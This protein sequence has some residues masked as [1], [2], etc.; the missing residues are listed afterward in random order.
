MSIARP[1]EPTKVTGQ[2]CLEYVERDLGFA[3]HGDVLNAAAIERYVESGRYNGT[4]VAGGYGSY[5]FQRD[6]GSFETELLK[7]SHDTTKRICG[8]VLDHYD[9]GGIKVAILG[10]ETLSTYPETC[11][12]L[13][14][15]M[16]LFYRQ[17]YK[18]GVIET[19]YKI[20]NLISTYP[21]VLAGSPPY[22]EESYSYAS[23]LLNEDGGSPSYATFDEFNY[24][25]P[26][27]IGGV[28]LSW[29]GQLWQYRG[30]TTSGHNYTLT[31]DKDNTL[32]GGVGFNS[33]TYQLPNLP[34]HAL[35]C[36]NPLAFISGNIYEMARGTL[37][38]LLSVFP[39]MFLNYSDIANYFQVSPSTEPFIFN[40]NL[41]FIPYNLILFEN[42]QDAKNYLANGVVTSDAYLYPLDF[43]NLPKYEAPDPDDDED[44]EDHNTPDDN[45]RET[46]ENLPETPTYTP[47]RLSNYNWYWIDAQELEGFID[48]FWNDVGDM[49]DW[50]DL[51][52]KIKGLYNDLASAILMIRYMPVDVNWIGGT[53]GTGSIKVGMIEK[54][55][56]YSMISDIS[57]P[58]VQLIGHIEIPKNYESFVDL[59][60]YAELSLYLPY[61]GIVSLDVDILTG[62]SLYVYG[63]YDH[64]NG[65]IQYYLYYDNRTLINTYIAKMAVDIPITLQSKYDR[66]SAIF[67]NVSNT[68]GG[69][70]SA[71]AGVASGNPIG[72]ALGVTQGVSALTTNSNA[73]A[74]LK[75]MGTVGETG[76]FYAPQKCMLYHRRAVIT[77]PSSWKQNVGEMCSKTLTLG[78]LSGLTTCYNPRVRFTNAAPTQDEI[79][80]IYDYLEKGVIL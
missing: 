40:S 13:Q 45:N 6:S 17:Y 70:I 10:N 54:T 52:D 59:A 56:T 53:S 67:S 62:H 39:G 77:K 35:M 5:L 31:N 61:Y 23:L 11:D 80:E 79:N 71:G 58:S 19:Q 15:R 49:S 41:T 29:L 16:S 8:L 66:D 28:N 60:P 4:I 26:E 32:V 22:S 63:L 27:F 25:E 73:S 72:I 24:F 75:V 37:F 50:S 74:P 44:A 34:Y 36:N 43:E 1:K 64:L 76:A 42:E 57:S 68:L 2:A 46:D 47:A 12:L 18:Q 55:G 33:I 7:F 14:E 30:A 20:D 65:T 69:L 48:W 51:V 9:D 21:Q 78:S 38:D 3:D